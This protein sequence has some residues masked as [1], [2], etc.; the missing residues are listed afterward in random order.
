MS[1]MAYDLFIISSQAISHI[2]KFDFRLY[3][4]PDNLYGV[5]NPETR[6]WNGIVKQLI[7]KRSVSYAFNR[8]QMRF[9]GPIWRWPP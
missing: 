7:D 6:E 4:V 3:T 5:F 1:W 8:R 2:S 9:Q